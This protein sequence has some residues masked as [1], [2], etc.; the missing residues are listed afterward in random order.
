MAPT[1]SFLF[2][3]APEDAAAADMP[4]LSDAV[5]RPRLRRQAPS[6]QGRQQQAA[7]GGGGVAPRKAPQRGLGVAELERLRCGGVDP[8]HD[9]NAAAAAAAML[10][11][12][13]VNMQAQSNSL[14]LQ[15][16]QQQLNLH[17]HHHHHDYLPATGSRYYSPLLVQ[18]PPAAPAPPAPVRY[19]QGVAPE[20]QYFMDHRWGGMGGIVPAGNGHSPQL[21]APAPE[22]SAAHGT[23]W[24]PACSSASCLH[25]GQRCDL[26]SKGTRAPAAAVV[27]TTNAPDYPMYDLTAAMAAARKETAGEGLLA[28]EGRKE[29]REIEFF[30]TRTSS[31]GGG[32]EESELRSTPAGGVDG[33]SAPLDLSLR[34]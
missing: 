18:P 4:V 34:L 16:Q 11:A 13:A 27:T 25:G 26:C 28:S 20:Q 7:G 31:D 6:G 22:Y 2:G 3:A 21:R 5:A 1:S 10:E 12:A 14:L 9:I 17:H 8:L 15:Q 23:I 33:G 30:P 19:V 24:R 32:P 29:V